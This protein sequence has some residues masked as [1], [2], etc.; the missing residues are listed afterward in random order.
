MKFTSEEQYIKT[1]APAAQKAG[2]KYRYLPSVLIGQTCLENGYGLDPSTQSLIDHNNMLGIKSELLNAS[3]DEY[4]VWSGK[5]FIKET[6][7]VYNGKHV[8]IR[9]SFRV[10]ETID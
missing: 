8:I 10:Y 2:L 6:P 3:W 7:E 9:D 4:T 1:V 5:S